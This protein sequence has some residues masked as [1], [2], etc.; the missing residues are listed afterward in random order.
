VKLP[1]KLTGN[2]DVDAMCV[3]SPPNLKKCRPRC[4]LIV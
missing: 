1:A 3:M 4:Q 2:E